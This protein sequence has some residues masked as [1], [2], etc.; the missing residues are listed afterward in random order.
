MMGLPLTLTQ[1]SPSRC[2]PSGSYRPSRATF[3]SRP[4]RLLIAVG[5]SAHIT[6]CLEDRLGHAHHFR[7][8]HAEDAMNS[9]DSYSS[10][11]PPYVRFKVEMLYL[12]LDQSQV[13]C[14]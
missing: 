13:R 12:A 6:A 9:R 3:V 7:H 11:K 2:S 1:A 10:D 4:G 5:Y 14:V 8:N